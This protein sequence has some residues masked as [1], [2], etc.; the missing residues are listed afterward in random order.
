M[1]WARWIVWSASR[2]N[3]TGQIP[4]DENLEQKAVGRLYSGKFTLS[5]SDCS[6]RTVYTGKLF[7]GSMTFDRRPI[8]HLACISSN[9]F[10][11]F[12]TFWCVIMNV[13]P[14]KEGST[15]DFL[16]FK[17]RLPRGCLG[18][19]LRRFSLENQ[20]HRTSQD[21]PTPKATVNIV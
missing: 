21:N 13:E 8:C 4:A 16:G 12:E 7:T 18:G 19:G 9:L 17:K 3:L 6:V 15:I 1:L 2:E 11:T 5:H 20:C 10:E 14:L